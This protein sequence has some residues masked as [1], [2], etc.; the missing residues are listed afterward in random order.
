MFFKIS[1]VVKNKLNDDRI[2]I[3]GWSIPLFIYLFLIFLLDGHK[4]KFNRWMKIS[5]SSAAS[6]YV[7]YVMY[8]HSKYVRMSH[9]QSPYKTYAH[10]WP[11]NCFFS[12]NVAWQP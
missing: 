3:F 9:I 8:I 1:S 11:H 7:I 10:L 6:Q 12:W 2:F 5:G 4:V